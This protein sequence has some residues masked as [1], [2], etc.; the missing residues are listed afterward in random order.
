MNFAKEKLRLRIRWNGNFEGSELN[1]TLK[2]NS[3][4]I[5]FELW[6]VPILGIVMWAGDT[7]KLN[8]VL[9][10]SISLRQ[11]LQSPPISTPHWGIKTYYQFIFTGSPI[12]HCQYPEHPSHH[13]IPAWDLPRNVSVFQVTPP[14]SPHQIYLVCNSTV[15]IYNLLRS[16]GQVVSLSIILNHSKYLEI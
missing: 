15:L 14:R 1:F 5:G 3:S 4:F 11:T 10:W 7:S 6:A 2:H 8:Q 16:S 9:S 12:E 13:D